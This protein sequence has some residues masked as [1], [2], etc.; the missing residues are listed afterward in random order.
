MIGHGSGKEGTH[1]VHGSP[2]GA[3]DL[4]ATK[5]KLGFDPTKVRSLWTSDSLMC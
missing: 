5:T 4:A 1:G 2:L 3:S